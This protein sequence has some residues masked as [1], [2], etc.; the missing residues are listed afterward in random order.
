MPASRGISEISPDGGGKSHP[1]KPPRQRGL[2]WNVALCRVSLTGHEHDSHGTGTERNNPKDYPGPH[3][4]GACRRRCNL[5]SDMEA[6]RCI[7]ASG[8][9]G[10][11]VLTLGKCPEVTCFQLDD[12]TALALIV[13]VGG[14]HIAVDEDFYEVGI[15][16]I[17]PECQPVFAALVP[18]A[19]FPFRDSGSELIDGNSRLLIAADRA[20]LMLGALLGHSCFPVGFPLE[21]V[22]RSVAPVFTNSALVPM[23]LA[24]LC[25]FG[26][27]CMSSKL[28][29]RLTAYCTD[30]FFFAGRRAA[31]VIGQLLPANIT[32]VIFVVV[33]TF[34][35][36]LAAEVTLVILVVVRALAQSLA[37]QVTLVIFVFVC[38]FTQRLAT[39]VALVILV[40]VGTFA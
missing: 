23:L 8:S 28:S 5:R 26:L 32:L 25:P 31:R 13:V 27:V 36:R 17:G 4:C 35:Q 9:D 21:G 1:K 12:D 2:L 38:A 20:F 15:C 29:I 14:D 40:V 30:R 10:D 37:A 6:D 22:S 3:T 16:R 11:G 34:A 39:Q 7:A 33:C 18:P 24:V 19:V